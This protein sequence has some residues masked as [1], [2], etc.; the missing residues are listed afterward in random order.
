MYECYRLHRDEGCAPRAA[1][2]LV[3]KLYGKEDAEEIRQLQG[4]LERIEERDRPPGDGEPPVKVATGIAS[5]Y[6]QERRRGA[7]DTRARDACTHAYGVR[8]QALDQ[9]LVRARR[10]FD[11]ELAAVAAES[12][13]MME[14]ATA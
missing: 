6:L 7:S 12:H 9:Q 5:L 13:P 11:A 4:T 14:E 10:E 1:T 2:E 8:G 3:A